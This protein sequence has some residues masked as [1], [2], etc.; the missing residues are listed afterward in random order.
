MLL[1][2][3]LL[4]GNVG[5]SWLLIPV[6][7]VLL[8]LFVGGVASI[9][10]ILNIY[11]RDLAQLVAVSMQLLFYL[12]PIIY[13]INLV[14]EEWHGLPLRSI[15]E[16]LPLSEF[17]DVV[18]ATELRLAGC[19]RCTTGSALLVWTAPLSGSRVRR[20]IRWRG[21]DVGESHERGRASRPRTCPSGSGCTA[22]AAQPSRSGWSVAGGTEGGEFWAAPRRVVRGRARQHVRHRRPQR[23][24]QVDAAAR[25]I[26]GIYRPTSGAVARRR[27]RSRRCSSSVPASTPSSPAGRTSA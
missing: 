4:F 2:V 15:I 22:S 10:S 1:V 18:P 20:A 13:S 24:G 17:V 11:F 25:C 19:R 9:C 8:A 5:A 27:P 6:W 21:Q 7:L 26:A 23:L 14:P 3:L 16:A 12:T